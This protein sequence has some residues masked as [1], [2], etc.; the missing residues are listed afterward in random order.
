MSSAFRL[1]FAPWPRLSH[2][3]ALATHW[4]Q[5]EVGK[6]A[7]LVLW[8]P[9]SFGAKPDMVIKGGHIA[10]AQ[11]VQPRV[12]PLPIRVPRCTGLSPQK[13]CMAQRCWQLG[14]RKG[15]GNCLAVVC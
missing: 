8:S 15:Q 14:R 4:A 2:V 6:L 7:D 11:M 5:V 13:M 12:H 1:L 10:W 3:S 9:A